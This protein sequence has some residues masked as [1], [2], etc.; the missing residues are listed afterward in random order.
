MKVLAAKGT[1]CP[2]EG[3]PRQYITDAEPGQNVPESAYYKR[4][5]KDGSL[6]IAPVKP[7]GKKEVK[8]DGK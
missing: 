6:V 1:R 5:V 8:A 2:M 3:K 7:A 4:L